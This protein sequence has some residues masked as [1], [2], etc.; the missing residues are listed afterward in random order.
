MESESPFGIFPAD[1]PVQNSTI[2]SFIN[3]IVNRQFRVEL[4]ETADIV[5][6][7]GFL[8]QCNLPFFRRFIPD[9]KSGPQPGIL[10]LAVTAY[11]QD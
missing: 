9:G 11:S 5:K 2:Q 7:P 4:V 10:G 6:K 8:F 3:L 1:Q